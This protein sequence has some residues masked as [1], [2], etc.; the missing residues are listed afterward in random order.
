MKQ[1]ARRSRSCLSCQSTLIVP[2]FTFQFKNLN[3]SYLKKLRKGE[4]DLNS[5]ET[6]LLVNQPPRHL[7]IPI[8][9]KY[10]SNILFWQ[11][12]KNFVFF[13]N[14]PADVCKCTLHIFPLHNSVIGLRP[15]YLIILLAN[16][17]CSNCNMYLFKLPNVFVPIAKVFV[18]IAK[19][20]SPN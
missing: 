14:Q 3:I 6:D 10:E 11:I 5:D 20:I 12:R 2:T 9:K 19:I 4:Q 15:L 16:C 17:I 1:E 8:S 18:Q 7:Y 13:H